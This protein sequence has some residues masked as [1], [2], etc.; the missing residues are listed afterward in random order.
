MCIG[1]AH[2]QPGA[3]LHLL[4]D[5][6]VVPAIEQL[7]S[8]ENCKLIKLVYIPP[9]APF[10]FDNDDGGLAVVVAKFINIIS[11]E[12]IINPC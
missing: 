9:F 12:S 2:V 5:S 8:R 1:S 6:Y 4:D 3:L 10:C 7:Q 11:R